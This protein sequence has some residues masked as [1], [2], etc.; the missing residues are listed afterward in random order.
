MAQASA[1]HK[2]AQTGWLNSRNSFILSE[3]WRLVS[4]RHRGAGKAMLI[5]KPLSLAFRP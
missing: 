3:C 5:L 4:P 2:I 1:C